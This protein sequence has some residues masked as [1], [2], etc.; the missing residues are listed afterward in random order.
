MQKRN[1]YQNS[2]TREIQ[3]SN[4]VTTSGT[5]DV[6]IGK[7][8]KTNEIF[9]VPSASTEGEITWFNSILVFF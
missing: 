2:K 1:I 6:L 8:E 3:F 7:A 4:W 5:P 9:N